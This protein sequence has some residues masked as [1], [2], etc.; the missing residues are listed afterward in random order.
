MER[1]KISE[2]ISNID[3][4]LIAEAAYFDI[5][6]CSDSSER[7]VKMKKQKFITIGIAAAFVMSLGIGSFAYY[8]W[9]LKDLVVDTETTAPAQAI[10]VEEGVQT[11]ETM[12]VR[13]NT[14]SLQGIAGSPEQKA[15]KAWNDFEK[16]YDKDRKILDKVGNSPTAWDEKYGRNGYFVYSQEMAD[17]LDSIASEYK[18]KLH[19]GGIKELNSAKDVYDKFGNF[20]KSDDI[21]GYYFEDGTFQCS[22]TSDGHDYQLRRCMKGTMD[23]V[24]LSTEDLDQYEQ[25][26]YK[27]AS[28][29]TVLIAMGP[30][31]G[32]II[33][34]LEN[35]FVNINIINGAEK[36]DIEKIA[37]GIDFGLL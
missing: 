37:D 13:T 12:F 5:E 15:M 20:C 30:C 7:I 28:G 34:D 18:L 22:I 29:K 32:L 8:Q 33:A 19:T 14:I 11:S 10:S 3:E 6:K 23:T 25:W 27:T 21:C 16:E 31:Q 1:E 24:S 26:E 35:S 36:A 4:D 9:H 2:I 17:K